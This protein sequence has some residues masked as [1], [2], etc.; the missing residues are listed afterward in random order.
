MFNQLI[1][2]VCELLIQSLT[3][4]LVL[5]PSP[6]PE[7]SHGSPRA[8]GSY[9]PPRVQLL[10]ASYQRTRLSPSR[11]EPEDRRPSQHMIISSSVEHQQRRPKEVDS[12]P[13]PHLWAP[14]RPSSTAT[15]IAF[16][17]ILPW[18][19][20]LATQA[21]SSPQVGYLSLLAIPPSFAHFVDLDVPR[22]SFSST[23]R[24][25][26]QSFLIR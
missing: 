12:P 18:P 21:E 11:G 7:L 25:E 9:P 10:C 13:D 20:H 4:N 23:T 16:H 3:T 19:P 15:Q 1:P 26:P 8:L 22:L 24:S 5:C 17:I 14:P 2:R 6:H